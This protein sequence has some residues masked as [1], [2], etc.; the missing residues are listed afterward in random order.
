MDV[1]KDY[2]KWVDKYAAAI[3]K[4]NKNPS[5]S[6]A[7]NDY[8]N[9]LTEL[10]QWEA[11]LADIGDDDDLTDQEAAKVM[12]EYDRITLKLTKAISKIGR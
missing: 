7:I 2:D 8:M 10:T 9:C 12:A 11:K 3:D 1:L 6:S 5:D 4:Y